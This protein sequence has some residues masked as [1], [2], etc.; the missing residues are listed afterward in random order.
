MP[1]PGK[2]TTPDKANIAA[3]LEGFAVLATEENEVER[4]AQLFAAAESLRQEIGGR[5]M[6]L[7]NRTMID[8]ASAAA[9]EQLGQ[10]AWETACDQGRA[11][12]MEQ[13][14]ALALQEQSATTGSG[15]GEGWSAP[16]TPSR[17][18]Y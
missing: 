2:P 4:A 9:R 5:L 7:R 16:P 11:M 12:A 8:E 18:T 10:P 15:I 14:V 1:S 6:S 13:A 17:E 3:G